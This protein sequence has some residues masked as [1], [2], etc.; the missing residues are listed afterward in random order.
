[1]TGLTSSWDRTSAVTRCTGRLKRLPMGP[2]RA[3]VGHMRALV[4]LF[5]HGSTHA[6]AHRDEQ[7]R[8]DGSWDGAAFRSPRSGSSRLSLGPAARAPA[9]AIAR[10]C[11]H[12]APPIPEGSGAGRSRIVDESRRERRLSIAGRFIG[13]AL[14]PAAG[15]RSGYLAMCLGQPDERPRAGHHPVGVVAA[16]AGR[17]PATIAPL[18]GDAVEQSR[19]S[20]VGTR[21]QPQVRQRVV[22]VAVTAVLADQEGRPERRRERGQH[23]LDRTQ[24]AVRR[25]STGRGAR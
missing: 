17:Q 22:H 13:P 5:T 25:P 2:I 14:P 1:M 3:P 23:R 4:G 11:A 10:P 20:G 15:H 9:P 19:G 18:V 6:A 24:P 8:A 7:Q 12:C 16:T 21:G